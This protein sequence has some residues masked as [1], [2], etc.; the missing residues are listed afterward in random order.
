MKYIIFYQTD[1]DYVRYRTSEV[2]ETFSLPYNDFK[3]YLKEICPMVLHAHQMYEALDSFETVFIDLQ[4]L[5]WTILR[6][7]IKELIE[8]TPFE[9][10]VQ[11]NAKDKKGN[12]DFIIKP[13]ISTKVTDVVDKL[14]KK[15]ILNLPTKILKT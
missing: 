5:S 6:K 8:T 12:D 14:W 13:V 3:K 9:S 15:K 10:L 2:E 4:N 7:D 1:Y 11:L